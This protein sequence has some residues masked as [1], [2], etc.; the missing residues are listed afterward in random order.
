MT[1]KLKYPSRILEAMHES[2][3][4]LF[5]GGAIDAAQMEKFDQM[6]LRAPALPKKNLK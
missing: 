6:C 5:A 2:A 3:R 1:E 4:D